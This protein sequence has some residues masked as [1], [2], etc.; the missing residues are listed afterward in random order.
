MRDGFS[1]TLKSWAAIFSC[2]LNLWLFASQP[3][4]ASVASKS[5]SW[6][7]PMDAS[8][9]GL[10]TRT[11][12]KGQSMFLDYIEVE[13]VVLQAGT[14]AFPSR[15][16]IRNNLSSLRRVNSR[17]LSRMRCTPLAR[18]A[19]RLFCREIPIRLETIPMNRLATS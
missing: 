2:L 12:L 11:I 5:Y 3:I 8:T 13:A 1:F 15:V 14:E 4:F 17:L 10:N 7:D 6:I 19:L 9:P 16:R 18:T